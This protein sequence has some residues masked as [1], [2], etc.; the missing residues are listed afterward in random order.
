MLANFAT[1]D[2]MWHFDGADATGVTHPSLRLKC[3]DSS[4]QAAEISANKRGARVAG[5]AS[6]A[7]FQGC[8]SANRPEREPPQNGEY[9]GMRR[10]G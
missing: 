9:G 10:R 4:I 5:R 1:A 7:S 3:D 2:E 6:R 8:G